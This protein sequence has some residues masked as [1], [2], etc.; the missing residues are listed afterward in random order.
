MKDEAWLHMPGG[1]DPST[2]GVVETAAPRTREPSAIGRT[3][4][5]LRRPFFPFHPLAMDRCEAIQTGLWLSHGEGAS[6]NVTVFVGASKGCGASTVASNFA[7]ALARN[8]ESRVLLI[9]FDAPR[10]QRAPLQRNPDLNAWLENRREPDGA[11]QEPAH[12]Y[13]LSSE[14]LGRMVFQV[15]QSCAFDEFLVR[16]RT[17]F[18]HVVIDAPSLQDHPETL[19]LCNKSD[20]VVLVVRAGQTR[21]ETALWA[22]EQIDRT[23]GHLAGVVLNRYRRYVPKWL[24]PT[25]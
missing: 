16:A 11:P 13:R 25:G 8:P 6:K 21:S 4:G 10:A 15:V 3:S 12:L 24:S 18:D 22:R 5:A 1:A 23:H 2:P 7:G 9:D 17:S 19:V 14:S 20:S